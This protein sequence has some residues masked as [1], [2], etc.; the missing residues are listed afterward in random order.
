MLYITITDHSNSRLKMVAQSHSIKNF[1]CI[2]CPLNFC[3][4]KLGIPVSVCVPTMLVGT[5]IYLFL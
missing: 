2:L 4:E 5:K 3:D 1:T